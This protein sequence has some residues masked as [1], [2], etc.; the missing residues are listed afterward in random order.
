MPAIGFAVG[1]LAGQHA[2]TSACWLSLLCL[3]AAVF[4]LY[5][6]P[7]YQSVALLFTIVALGALRS[8]MVRSQHEQVA[9]P[10][11]EV[12]YKAVITSE[13]REKP[14][15][16]LADIIIAG[17]GRKVKCYISKD[18]L[19]RR[20]AIGDRLVLTSLIERNREW[21]QGTFNYRRYLEVH[22]F[23]GQTFVRQGLWHL[24]PGGWHGLSL[25]QRARLR[26]LCYRHYLLQRYRN[27]GYAGDE[28]AVVA[29]MTLGDKSAMTSELN[30]VYAVSGASHVLA[31]SGLHLG[32]IYMLLALVVVGRRWRF[33]T[34][35]LAVLGIWA[36]AMLVG[37]PLSVVRA[38]VM[39]SVYG[40][41]SLLGR[42]RLSLNALA[43]AALIILM[44]S[45]YSL[46]DVGFQL[47]FA[48]MMA[49]LT[50]Q[51]LFEHAV[52]REW[53]MAHPVIRSVWG[54]STVS[55]AAQ[56]GTAPLVAYYFGRFSTWFLLT[57]FIVIPATTAILY[58][59]LATLLI[60]AAGVVLLRIVGWLNTALALIATRLPCPSIE[61]LRPSLVQ[62]VVAYIVIVCVAS[63]VRIYNKKL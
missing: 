58:L 30:E 61:G 18:S 49:I 10:E 51:P 34:Q 50:V 21:Q 37:L 20:L 26:F 15:T 41:L 14:K 28:Y 36:F 53:L 54:L 45:P 39:I 57:N 7:L 47:S 27:M 23:A 52:R 6:W 22:G 12:T 33:A 25:W 56:L 11:G 1:I 8:A 16:M 2:E 17:D 4:A 24:S 32:I 29:A 55:V 13:V 38:A 63:A 43:L 19:S 3:L 42:N 60:P 62:T 31:L 35:V 46:W 40:L 9:W 5:R 44:V 48:A 59:A